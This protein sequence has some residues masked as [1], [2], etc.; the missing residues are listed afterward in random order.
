MGC[1]TF[2]NPVAEA[3]TAWP[4]QEAL[5][6]P[7]EQVFRILHESTRQPMPSPVARVLQE[8]HIVHLANHTVLC[9]RD[10]REVVITDSGAPIRS[11]NGELLGVVMVFQ[12]VS[13]QQQ[14]ETELFRARKIESVGVLAGGIAHDFNNLLTGI[15][16]N[17][18]F[19]KMLAREEVIIRRLAE[20]EKACERATALTHQ[21]LTF[22]KGGTPIRETVSIVDVLYESVSFALR[23][24]NVR[25]DFHVASDLWPVDIDEG[26]INQVLHNVVL[27]AVHAMPEGGT[28][29]VR[30]E[31]VVRGAGV[32]L[33]M[34]IKLSTLREL[35]WHYR[36]ATHTIMPASKELPYDDHTTGGPC[37]A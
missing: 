34:H 17:I 32:R 14:M 5:G 3:L 21:L 25:A 30:A 37:H 9:T 13:A 27:N 28:I 10:G 29:R 12:D 11:T 4:A 1:I 22:A 31:N 33:P 8:G 24:A 36:V 7:I 6:Q 35:L 18:S 16:G 20:A 26:Q 19:A 2:M 15:L 23:G